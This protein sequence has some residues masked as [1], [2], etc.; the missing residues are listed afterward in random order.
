MG[1]VTVL[2]ADVETALEKA[3]RARAL[4]SWGR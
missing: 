2:G 4:L 3:E 1:H